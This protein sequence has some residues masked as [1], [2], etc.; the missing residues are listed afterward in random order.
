M[1]ALGSMKFL[2]ALRDYKT[3]KPYT[4]DFR[5]QDWESKIP[6]SNYKSQQVDE[7]CIKDIRGK[8]DHFTFDTNGFAVIEL[9]SSMLYE[10]F[11]DS[12]NLDTVYCE[13][14]ASCLLRYFRGAAAVQIYDVEVCAECIHP[15]VC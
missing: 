5:I 14:I 10:G 11:E 12:E 6:R 4:I 8:E 2:K 1:D 13:E 7:I 15:L 9:E 3:H